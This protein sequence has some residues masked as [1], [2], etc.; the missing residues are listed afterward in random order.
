MLLL[1][2][3]MADIESDSF[4]CSYSGGIQGR[5]DD[6]LTNWCRMPAETREKLFQKAFTAYIESRNKSTSQ[7]PMTIQD[8]VEVFLST[9][10]QMQPQIIGDVLEKMFEVAAN[11]SEKYLGKVVTDEE[12][13]IKTKDRALLLVMSVYRMAT[14]HFTFSDNIE[15]HPSYNEFIIGALLMITRFLEVE[16]EESDSS[17]RKCANCGATEAT[18]LCGRCKRQRYCSVECQKSDWKEHKLRCQPPTSLI[19]KP[20]PK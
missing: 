13:R 6:K 8:E 11:Y 15:L 7:L 14:N 4:R 1:F 2:W 17:S 19:L 18:K 10:I 9:T 3:M 16:D 12:G 5:I 20:L